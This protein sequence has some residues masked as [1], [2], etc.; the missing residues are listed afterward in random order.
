MRTKA[1]DAQVIGVLLIRE[2]QT[3]KDRRGLR[4]MDGFRHSIGTRVTPRTMCAQGMSSDEGESAAC[5]LLREEVGSS[6]VSG[7]KASE[8]RLSALLHDR[9]RIGRE[10]HDS[11]L[12]ALYAIRLT[13][14]QH[15][16][17]HPSGPVSG[18]GAHNQAAGQLNRLIQDI[19]RMILSVE[20]DPVESFGLV[21]ELHALVQAIEEVSD[22]Q[23]RIG[24]DPTAEEILTGEEA[25]ELVMITRD[26]LSNSV[27]HAQATRI[28]I[29][30]RHLGSR[31]QLSIRD[32]GAGF[33][34]G[35]EAKKGA[36]FARMEDRMRKIGGRLNVQSTVG[37]G[38]CITAYV[39]LE[40]ILTPV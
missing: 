28:V 7:L 35:L 15:S 4:I 8:Q 6:L 14:E 18:F 3:M 39:Y 12:Q 17:L 31:V 29:A 26:A 40:P 16:E 30:L 32:D 36:G 21:S 1:E 22:V 20:S 19:Q 23:I 24:I 9:G 33:D 34:V 11:V 2:I 38:T 37:R 25:R 5:L 27:R 10:L 13:L